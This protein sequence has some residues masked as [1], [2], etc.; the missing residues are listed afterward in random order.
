MEKLI[1]TAAITGSRIT[2]KIAPNIPITPEEIVQSA[3]EC[4]EAGAAVVHIH[5]R[6]PGDGSGDPKF[7]DFQAG[8]GTLAGENQLNSVFDHQRH[9]G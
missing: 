4:W 7:R 5:V 6:D 8:R 2:R 3:V 9:P 1:I